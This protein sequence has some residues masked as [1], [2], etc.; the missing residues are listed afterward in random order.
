MSA[1]SIRT[2]QIWAQGFGSAPAA[3]EATV[4]NTLIFSGPVPTV[5]EPMQE[6][7]GP[8]YKGTGQ[9]AFS[10]D[11]PFD[12]VGAVPVSIKVTDQMVIVTNSFY[13]YV[14]LPGTDP[15]FPN[16]RVIGGPDVFVAIAGGELTDPKAYV[17]INSVLKIPNRNGSEEMGE[18]YW[19]LTTNDVLSFDLEISSPGIY[20]LRPPDADLTP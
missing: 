11:I 8:Q 13:N 5:D 17:K 16:Q 4:N 3:I 19:P 10:F 9:L 7:G 12:F 6:H 18:W 20:E 2:V 1:P 14:T 15:D